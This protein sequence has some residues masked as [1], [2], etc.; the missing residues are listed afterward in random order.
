MRQGES[1]KT[2]MINT[3]AFS[4]AFSKSLSAGVDV[5][6]IGMSS[7]ISGS[8][9]AAVIAAA[10]LREQYPDRK[11]ATIDTRAASLGEGLPV[12]FAARLHEAGATF[13]E[14]AGRQSKT[15]HSFASISRSKTL[16]T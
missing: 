2:S 10:E 6:Y 15:A 14:V 13:D 12:L 7:G 4:T 8:H 9:H 3:S 1:V 5:L 16:C 11:I